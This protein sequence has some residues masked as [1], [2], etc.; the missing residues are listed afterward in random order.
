MARAERRR[1]MA[2][3][4]AKEWPVAI[5]ICNEKGIILEMNNRAVET[6][7]D[8]G[9]EN[10]IGT[11]VLDCHPQPARSKLK[12][13]M[14]GRRTN[15]YTIEKAGRKKLIHQAPWYKDGRYAGF[16]ELS[17]EIPRSMPHFNRDAGQNP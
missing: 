14:D 8:S 5:T 17:F 13:L 1:F 16:I 12:G 6:F 15:V 9:G 2:P 11:D 4:W 3:E 7:A 10:L